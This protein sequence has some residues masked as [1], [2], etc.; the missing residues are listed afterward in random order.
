MMEIEFVHIN[1]KTDPVQFEKDLML[2]DVAWKLM[3]R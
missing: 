1:E 3:C 2:Q